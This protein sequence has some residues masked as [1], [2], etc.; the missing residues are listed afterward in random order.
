MD[1]NEY[2]DKNNDPNGYFKCKDEQAKAEQEKE[3]E[4][5][6]ANTPKYIYASILSPI[7]FLGG[8]A[9][10]FNKKTGFW[11]GWGFAILG[12]IVL[13]GVGAG[14]DRAIHLKNKK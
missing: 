6:L 5:Y 13:G 2:L 12:S 10:A 8:V 1:C 3:T 9:Y 11:K 4:K 14:I 7:G